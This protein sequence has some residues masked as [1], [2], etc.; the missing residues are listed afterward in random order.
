MANFKKKP[1]VNELGNAI[2]EINNRVNELINV[3]H[4]LD[5]ILGMYIRMEGKL[6]E[7]NEYLEVKTKEMID[8]QKA[9]GKADKQDIQANTKDEGSGSKGVRKKD[10]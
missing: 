8:E 10:N 2:V 6:D 4:N 9:N 7:F 5:N 1:T 3:A